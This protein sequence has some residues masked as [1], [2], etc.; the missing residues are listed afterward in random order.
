MTYP[1]WRLLVRGLPRVPENELDNPSGVLERVGMMA[2]ARFANHF[3]LATQLLESLLNKSGV[4]CNRYD[5]VTGTHDVQERDFHL[6]QWS[7][8]IDGISPELYRCGLGQAIGLQAGLPTAGTSFADSLTAGPTLE[9]ADRGIGI[10]AV[11]FLGIG[12]GPVVDDQAATAHTFEGD[13]CRELVVTGE[14]LVKTIPVFDR[15]RAA[16]KICHVTV[17]QV[18]TSFQQG[19]VRLRFMSEE[20]SSPDPGFPLGCVSWCHDNTATLLMDEVKSLVPI[21]NRLLA[22]KRFGGSRGMRDEQVAQYQ[23]HDI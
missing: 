17:D 3:D 6:R 15:N 4:F 20:A 14:I 18:E 12:R 11:D 5:L 7:Q 22:G 21:P 19:E 1:R 8:L 23:Q 9:V 2:N 13:F 16:I 10:D